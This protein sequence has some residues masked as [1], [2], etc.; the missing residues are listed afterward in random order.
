MAPE[1]SGLTTR[2]AIKKLYLDSTELT[3][4]KNQKMDLLSE[5]WDLM[6]KNIATVY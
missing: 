1:Q 3:N 5:N 4:K 6:N 2:P